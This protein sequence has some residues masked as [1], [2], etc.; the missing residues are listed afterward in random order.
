MKIHSLLLITPTLNSYEVSLT[1]HPTKEQVELALIDLVA[2]SIKDLRRSSSTSIKVRIRLSEIQSRL[3]TLP[4]AEKFES[5]MRFINSS[6][7][8]VHISEHD[9]NT[10]Q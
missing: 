7:L 6:P 4:H 5:S 8:N 2:K 9:V 1:L 10:E 3:Q